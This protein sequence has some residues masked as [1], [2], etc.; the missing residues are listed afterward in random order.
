M[1]IGKGNAWERGDWGLL[2]WKD[3][4]RDEFPRFPATF[5]DIVITFLHGT[6]GPAYYKRMFSIKR[7]QGRNLTI[8]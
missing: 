3:T 2:V 8:D 4:F 5:P 6:A 7:I 1:A